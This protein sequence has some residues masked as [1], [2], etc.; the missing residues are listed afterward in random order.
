MSLDTGTGY[1]SEYPSTSMRKHPLL[2]PFALVRC[3]SDTLCVM[4]C[5]LCDLFSFEIPSNTARPDQARTSNKTSP[6]QGLGL[7]CVKPDLGE[8]GQERIGRAERGGA[9]LIS[10]DGR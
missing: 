9:C 2:T 7:V 10:G 4:K 6:L 5:P 3:T 8:T 1:R